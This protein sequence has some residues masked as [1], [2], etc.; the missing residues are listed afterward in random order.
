MNRRGPLLTLAAVAVLAIVLLVINVSKESEPAAPAATPFPAKASA[1][2]SHLR[3][4]SS[5]PL[6]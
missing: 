1:S 5:E 6:A 4:T 2:G 3:S